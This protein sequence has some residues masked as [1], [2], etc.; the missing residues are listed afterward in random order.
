M[1]IEW[2]RDGA[3]FA[4]TAYEDGTGAEVVLNGTATLAANTVYRCP[5]LIKADVGLSLQWQQTAAGTGAIASARFL[6]TN[7][8][9]VDID[10]LDRADIWSDVS[11]AY[12]FTGLPAGGGADSEHY[13]IANL[14]GCAMQL[15]ITTGGA[16]VTGVSVLAQVRT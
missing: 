6:I 10:E 14:Q 4:L 7:T 9:D 3:S 8:N 13:P 15:E 12:A 5:L 11:S 2:R 16:A 1:A